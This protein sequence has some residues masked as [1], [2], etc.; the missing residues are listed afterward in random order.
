MLLSTSCGADKKPALSAGSRPAEV[1]VTPPG[2]TTIPAPDVACPT[3]AEPVRMCWSDAAATGVILGM[4]RDITARDD[5]LCWLRIWF[6]Y[7][8]CPAP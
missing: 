5:M 3:A 8:A 7:E 2:R 1:R 4:D 6:G